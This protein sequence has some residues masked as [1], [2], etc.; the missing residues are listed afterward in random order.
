MESQRGGMTETIQ[1][2]LYR[3]FVL[4]FLS[5]ST[6][7]VKNVWQDFLK[8]NTKDKII[9][10]QQGKRQKPSQINFFKKMLDKQKQALYNK[11]VARGGR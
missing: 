6:E 11:S 4:Y 2:S 8:D 1:D 7:E 5:R 9:R 10:A 3:A